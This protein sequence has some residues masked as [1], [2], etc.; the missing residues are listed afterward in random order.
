MRR[1]YEHIKVLSGG[2]R[3]LLASLYIPGSR[4]ALPSV[5][6]DIAPHLRVSYAIDRATNPADIMP[7]LNQNSLATMVI[8]QYGTHRGEI[9]QQIL[10]CLADLEAH[11]IPSSNPYPIATTPGQETLE[12]LGDG[13]EPIVSAELIPLHEC[14][15]FAVDSAKMLME[16]RAGTLLLQKRNGNLHDATLAPIW[17]NSLKRACHTLRLIGLLSPASSRPDLERGPGQGET[18]ANGCSN[19][20]G[21]M[22]RLT[23]EWGRVA[24]GPGNS[25]LQEVGLTKVEEEERRYGGEDQ[26]HGQGVHGD[27]IPQEDGVDAFRRDQ[28]TQSIQ[29]NHEQHQQQ[30]HSSDALSDLLQQQQQQQQQHQHHQSPAMQ[31]PSQ[32]SYPAHHPFP[33][34][35]TSGDQ[36]EAYPP[37]YPPLPPQQDA[38]PHGYM[39]RSDRWMAGGSG[40]NEGN[41]EQYHPSNGAGSAGIDGAP[42]QYHHQQ[43]QQQQQHPSNSHTAYPVPS[44]QQHHSGPGQN[45][46][47][48]GP[49]GAGGSGHQGQGQYPPAP[50]ALDLLLSQMFQYGPPP[51]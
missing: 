10:N 19:I 4:F 35:M 2:L 47:G 32:S 20:L 6:T 27:I 33:S 26:Y 28:A 43:Q 48:G 45:M 29:S 49:G 31:P 3:C 41:H 38:P 46:P 51:Q 16:A 39:D 42:D 5:P 11:V 23:E 44:V 15:V 14:I 21:S 30:Q 24:E 7:A 22:V 34:S 17:V 9:C 37:T 1:R 40:E 36:V 12:T 18:I 25:T 50:T 13:T 8:W